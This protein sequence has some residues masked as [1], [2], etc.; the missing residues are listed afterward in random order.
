MIVLNTVTLMGIDCVD[1]VRLQV[2]MDMCEEKISFAKSK[3][4]T[5][6]DID[7]SRFVRIKEISSYEQFSEF[8]LSDLYKYVDTEFVL[9]VQWDG[10]ILYPNSWK[11]EYLK[12]DY[13]GSPWVVKD[14]SIHDFGFPEELRGSLVVGNGG[15]CIR[16]KK[17]LKISSALYDLGLIKNYHPEDIAISMWYRDMFTSRGIVFAPSELAKDF[18]LEGDDFPLVNQFGFHGFY[19][20]LDSW[21]EKN[22]KYTSI[23]DSYLAYKKKTKEKWKPNFYK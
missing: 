16:S 17:F 22:P 15:F 7:D 11:D 4:L 6:K 19:T 23:H 20:D 5:S 9:L 18:A 13:I 2:V 10:F 14:W 3:L 12:Y 21:F 1:P 8:C